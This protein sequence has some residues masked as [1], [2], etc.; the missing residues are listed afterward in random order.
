MY[1]QGFKF[2][3]VV[4]LLCF[5]AAAGAAELNFMDAARFKG[6][7]SSKAPMVLADIQKP[8]DFKKHHFFAAVET[9]AYPVKTGADKA[10]LAV[11]QQMFQKTGNDV[12]VIGPR[13]GPASKRAA[14]YL[15]EQGI[16]ADK[17][18]ILEGGVKK[19]PD[20]EMLLDV[21]GGCA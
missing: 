16:P 20:Q 3:L 4:S 11:I 17:V 15:I 12:I 21:A 5:A 1:R 6:L 2:V 14:K 19:W 10:K 18:F 9:D 7:C 13:G 8:H